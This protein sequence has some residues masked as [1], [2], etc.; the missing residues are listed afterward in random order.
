M[1]VSAVTLE[2]LV[3]AGLHGQALIDVVRSID[4]DHAPKPRSSGA[5]R[6]ASYR[7]RNKEVSQSD[8]TGDVTPPLETKVPP[9]PP[10]KT[11]TLDSPLQ[12]T[13][14]GVQKVPPDFGREFHEVFWPE[15]P[16]KV[17]KPKA[18]SAYRTSRKRFPLET[19]MAGLRRYV[20]GREADRPWLNPATFL[21]QERFNDQPAA[22][23][24]ASAELPK[25]TGPDAR[26]REP[27]NSEI[28]QGWTSVHQ[29]EEDDGGDGPVLRHQARNGAMGGVDELVF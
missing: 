14:K 22:V 3:A 20:A 27:E 2:L 15:Y 11:Q 9:T 6:Q 16:H 8:V 13:P 21:N 29:D 25:W 28:L 26:D 19:I 10:S 17:G 4:A 23:E 5:E 24:S 1:P 7:Q 18:L 12:N